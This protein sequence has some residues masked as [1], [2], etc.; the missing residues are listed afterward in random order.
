M[1]AVVNVGVKGDGEREGPAKG[2]SILSLVWENLRRGPAI[3]QRAA[4]K[5]VTVM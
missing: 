5:A 3:L 1:D 4:E 2:R